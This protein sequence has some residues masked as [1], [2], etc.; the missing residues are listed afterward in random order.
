V[1]HADAAGVGRADADLRVSL[2]VLGRSVEVVHSIHG[3]GPETCEACGGAMRKALTT[4]AIVFKGSGWAKKDA[5]S[6]SKPAAATTASKDGSTDDAPSGSSDGAAPAASADSSTKDTAAPV[7]SSASSSGSGPT[8]TT[9]TS[10]SG[11]TRA[12]SGDRSA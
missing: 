12:G 6:A 8:P 4:P 1:R 9:T 5:R 11:A 10:S 2:H 3:A 7:P